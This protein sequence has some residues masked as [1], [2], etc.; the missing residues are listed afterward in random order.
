MK[1]CT[2]D[3]QSNYQ[4]INIKRESVQDNMFFLLAIDPLLEQ[5]TITG[6][7]REPGMLLVSNIRYTAGHPRL[8]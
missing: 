4:H 3:L 8:V 7:K 1:G 6:E 5:Q 2:F